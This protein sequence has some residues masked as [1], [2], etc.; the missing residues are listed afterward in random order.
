MSGGHEKS[1]QPD[2]VAS[3]RTDSVLSEVLAL[4]IV[5]LFLPQQPFVRK[6]KQAL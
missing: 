6:T 1:L 3:V 2:S 5:C 4:L